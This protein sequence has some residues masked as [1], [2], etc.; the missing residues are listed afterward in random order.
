[1]RP[2]A[3]H[4]L[5]TYKCNNFCSHCFVFSGPDKNGKVLSVNEA[6]KLFL[7]A[8]KLGGIEMVYLEGGEPFLEYD[9]MAGVIKRGCKAG[10]KVGVITNCLWARSKEMAM[11]KLLPIREY[12][13]ELIFS[14]DE[15]HNNF[16]EVRQAILA[17]RSLNIPF[18]INTIL[19]NA[20]P[21]FTLREC[22]YT[23]PKCDRVFRYGHLRYVGRAS[24]NL[25]KNVPKRPYYVFTKCTYYDVT[26]PFDIHSGLAEPLSIHID[27]Y[28]YVQLC[29]GLCIGNV[30]KN[31][32]DDIIKNYKPLE[33]PIIG[34]IL[35]GGPARLAK[36]FG[37]DGEFVDGC[38]LCYTVRR[39]L[40]M[41]F[42]KILAPE[43]VYGA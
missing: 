34:P 7:D 42:P 24:E 9:A 39:Q 14:C 12:I 23:L 5:L 29:Q 10:L 28:G 3:L 17:A 36:D 6:G 27:P 13:T 8:K 33:H 4:L 15:Y 25:T 21:T 11:A 41:R 18:V 16:K 22:V 20:K 40:R 19:A 2:K 35:R 37:L 30:F 1:M 43:V 31:S 38:Q 32:L 26:S